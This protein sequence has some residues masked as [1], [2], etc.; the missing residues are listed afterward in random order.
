MRDRFSF[1]TAEIW[2][3]RGFCIAAGISGW[4]LMMQ[5]L[6]G[7]ASWIWGLLHG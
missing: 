1:D 4:V 2:F 3:W 7:A 5:A 6:T